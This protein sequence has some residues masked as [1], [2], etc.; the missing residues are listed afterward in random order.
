MTKLSI[1]LICFAG[2]VSLFAC[3]DNQALTYDYLVQHPKVLEKQAIA[4][5]QSNSKT[6]QCEVVGHAAN[7]FSTLLSE[8]QA[9]PELFGMQILK[10]QEQLV[11]L[12][13]KLNDAQ[14]N[15]KEVEEA[16]RNY[17]TQLNKVKTMLAVVGIMSVH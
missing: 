13:Q 2:L 4:C 15:S 7:D 14:G 6:S 10:E 9:S 17:Q 3:K 1:K 16:T 5:Q 11:A 12:R 8:Q